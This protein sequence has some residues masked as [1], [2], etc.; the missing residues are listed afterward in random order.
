MTAV[1]STAQGITPG[2]GQTVQ[3]AGVQVGKI[4]DVHLEDGRAVLDLDMDRDKVDDGLVRTDAHALLRPRTP[5]KDMYLQLFPGSW[6]HP[7][8]GKGFR[9]PLQGTLTDV[10][11]DDLLNQL[12]ART[13]DY[14]TMLVSG[15]GEG[16]KGRGSDLAE[17][18]RRFGPTVRD[19]GRVNRSVA[20][21]RVALRA[22]VSEF[23]KL[24]RTL[25]EHP[26]ELS[27]LV[28]ASS[29]TFGAFASE[30][31]DLQDTIR[32]LP[33]TLRRA[34][35]T[36][37]RVQPLANALGPA[38]RALTPAVGA[39][40]RANPSLRALGREATPIVRTKIRPFVRAARPV[41]QDLRPAAEQ[42]D[43]SL[44]ELKRDTAVL[45]HLFNMLA[46]NKDGAEPASKADRDEGYL[47]WLAWA[48]HQG[49][50]LINVDDANGPMR[51]IFLAGTC[52]TLTSLVNFMPQLEFGMALSPLLASVCGNPQTASIGAR[53]KLSKNG[54]VRFVKGGRK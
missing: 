2:Q 48:T 33:G 54:K 49:L 37:Q 23:A 53:A 34:T 30:D 27:R 18:F 16:L 26:A 40:R 13:R 35:V 43:P 1:L 38:T 25:A 41:V 45:E 3:V 39:L 4:A 28:S 9:I 47:F 36:L 46:Y 10:N 7:A 8:A 12:D 6:K 50:N 20:N 44:G 51:P 15:T 14:L 32:Q 17:V 42:L 19:L 21:E 31:A 5:L 22:A 29:D 11:F 52:A 24:S